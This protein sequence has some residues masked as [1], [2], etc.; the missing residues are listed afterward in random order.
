MKQDI[1]FEIHCRNENSIATIFSSSNADSD[2]LERDA[3]LAFLLFSLRQA[4]NLKGSP[5]IQSLGM[6]MGAISEAGHSYF[7]ESAKMSL[8]EYSAIEDKR[9]LGDIM[10]DPENKQMNFKLE[11]KG[12]GF[13][14]KGV[15]GYSVN[16]ILLLILYFFEKFNS[17]A[18]EKKFRNA[19]ELCGGY[20]VMNQVD[21]TNQNNIA[22]TI[23]NEIGLSI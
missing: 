18:F 7:P 17:V 6:A 11:V 2:I 14:A 23:M 8:L 10:F 3:I 4:S 12:F 5:M 19:I 21:L 16:A 22:A 13:F 9:F 15:D 1:K 20:I